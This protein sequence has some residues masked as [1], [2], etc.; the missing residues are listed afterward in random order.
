MGKY[1]VATEGSVL[2]G[3]G[4]S[5]HDYSSLI[6]GIILLMAIAIQHWIW[7]EHN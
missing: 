4:I 2:I 3:C 1:F 6:A 7:K 5:Y